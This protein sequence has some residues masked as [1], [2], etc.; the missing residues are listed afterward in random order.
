MSQWL[1]SPLCQWTSACLSFWGWLQSHQWCWSTPIHSR[2]CCLTNKG[3]TSNNCKNATGKPHLSLLTKDSFFVF[4]FIWLLMV[5]FVSLVFGVLCHAIGIKD[6]VPV[7][8]LTSLP[9]D[10][11]LPFLGLPASNI[12]VMLANPKSFK[13][14]FSH[15]QRKKRQQM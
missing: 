11:R 4:L 6:K 2:V 14:V 9:M 13:S 15:Q 5:P 8:L 1:C 10:V 12:L 3:R 7:T